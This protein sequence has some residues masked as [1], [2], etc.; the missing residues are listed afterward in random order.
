MYTLLV[1]LYIAGISF[2]AKRV[3]QTIQK[4]GPMHEVRTTVPLLVPYVVTVPP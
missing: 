4:G 1:I 3:I 2:F